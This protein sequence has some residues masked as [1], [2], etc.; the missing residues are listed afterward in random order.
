M[1]TERLQLDKP[2]PGAGGVELPGLPRGCWGC[3]MGRPKALAA[4]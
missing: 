3:E 2:T 1:L 4:S